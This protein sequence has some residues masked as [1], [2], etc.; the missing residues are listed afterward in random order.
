MDVTRSR[1]RS[2]SLT[3]EAVASAGGIARRRK[4]LSKLVVM[5][6]AASVWAGALIYL[7]L[8]QTAA[9]LVLG[10]VAVFVT[11][12]A[13]AAADDPAAA[14]LAVAVALSAGGSATG[15][16]PQVSPWDKIEH[17]CVALLITLTL[18]RQFARIKRAAGLAKR[19]LLTLLAWGATLVL[20]VVWEILETVSDRLAGT[21]YNLGIHDTLGDL[22]VA[23]LGASI[24]AL[25]VL[26]FAAASRR[27]PTLT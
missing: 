24:A 5:L 18:D 14:A 21:D 11:A 27:K 2:G 19:R 10:I 25:A 26:V 4:M 16:I 13:M 8:A 23:L 22:A 7:I 20:V 1:R 6:A 15:V 3:K 12:L 9:T 17:G